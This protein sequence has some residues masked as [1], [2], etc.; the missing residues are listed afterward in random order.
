MLCHLTLAEQV[1]DESPQ[2]PGGH[3]R[4][5]QLHE[6]AVSVRMQFDDEMRICG[7]LRRRLSP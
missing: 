7:E 6:S 2:G 1:H 5:L 3:L 4:A